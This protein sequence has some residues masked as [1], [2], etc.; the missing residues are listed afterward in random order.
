MKK[1]FSV[2][3]AI[4]LLFSSFLVNQPITAQT[5][6][7]CENN[8]LY[9]HS[10]STNDSSKT[11]LPE[12]VETEE[13][14]SI[15]NMYI[16]RVRD[17][18]KDLNTFVFQNANG[19]QTMKIYGHPVKYID[20]TGNIKDISTKLQRL[21]N[22]DYQTAENS[23][24]TT[25]SKELSD[26][27]K[28]N[29]DVVDITMV[30]VGVP[31]A[32]I[33]SK[34]NQT[35]AYQIDEN[36]SL[37][38]SLTYTGFKEDIVVEKYTGQ[39]EYVFNLKTNGLYLEK[40][41]ES[42]KLF[43]VADNVRAVIGDVIIFTADE[44]NNA[45]GYMSSETVISGYEYLIT[46]H[47]DDEY[48]ADEKTKYP[49]RI[50][51]TIEIDS[52]DTTGSIEDVTIN[53]LR[54][55]DGSS[56]SL[57]VGNRNTYGIT[58]SL[59][60]FPGLDLDEIYESD[61]IQS[62]VVSIRD[63]MCQ[64]DQLT[65]ECRMFTGNEWSESTASWSNV[66][67]NSYSSTVLSTQ[68]V[69][70]SIGNTLESAHRYE[71]DITDAVCDWVDG[72][73]NRGIIFK[74]TDSVE[75]GST[76]I[77]KSFGSF[78]RTSYQPSITVEFVEHVFLDIDEYLKVGET[79]Q[80]Q[81][82]PSNYTVYWSSKNP[83][84]AT[85][86]STGLVT[87]ISGGITEIV[88]RYADSVT[89]SQV[90]FTT[91]IEVYDSIG[92]D[93]G[94]NYY[95]MNASSQRLLAPETNTSG[96]YSNVYA[97]MCSW[98]M[99]Q[100]WTIHKLSDGRFTVESDF[101]GSDISLHVSGTNI[102]TDGLFASDDSFKFNIYRIDTG[103]CQ[104][105]YRIMYGNKFVSENSNNNVYLSDSESTAS[106]WSFM[107]VD[108]GYADIFDFQNP[109][110]NFTGATA[111]ALD[112]LDSLGYT[113]RQQTN[114][115]HDD[116]F[117]LLTNTDDIFIFQG[118]GDDTTHSIKFTDDDGNVY[119]YIEAYHTTNTDTSKSLLTC[120]NNEL[121]N[122]RCVL[123]IGCSTAYELSNNARVYNLTKTTYELGAHFVLGTTESVF[124]REC[125]I[126]LEAFLEYSEAGFNIGESVSYA[127]EQAANDIYSEEYFPVQC[128]GDTYQKLNNLI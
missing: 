59:M 24:I 110:E 68:N 51:P 102:E 49:I 18:E 48:L 76:K 75:N 71:F 122:L 92:L 8:L 101:A 40:D 47:V 1:K 20:S 2:L 42:Y 55:S 21:N 43:D 19:S 100:R 33:I 35:V 67:P 4:I 13:D 34:D 116:A 85:V 109:S 37:E 28:L 86:S 79:A 88:T 69:S 7:L 30:P 9:N 53:S 38:Y 66:S 95:I 121:S 124:T 94:K 29:H 73:A 11:P 117:S 27:I 103:S 23:I 70:Y 108:A 97:E 52:S 39:T 90:L 126:F 57:H 63:I 54:G 45:F 115:R 113:A 14:A 5:D 64:S 44:S 65:I 84:I 17:K 114:K 89:G 41:E 62:A 15:T 111:N 50:D 32:R 98:S 87:A 91:Q 61:Q 16:G 77:A 78:N 81:V 119:G 106:Y 25:F 112:V 72:V 46:I 83:S 58:R 123:Y 128:Y 74:A 120:T 22:G 12:I 127:I 107:P 3:L 36:T 104:G 60:K 31:N 10:N 118:H 56:T 6:K 96:V 125:N 93:D 80:F 26:G 99:K 82:Y 105:L